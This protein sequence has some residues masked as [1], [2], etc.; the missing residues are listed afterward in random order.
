MVANPQWTDLVQDP[1]S[2][3]EGIHR[4]NESEVL[5]K[6]TGPPR[7]HDRPH[8]RKFSSS[9]YRNEPTAVVSSTLIHQ[10]L[11]GPGPGLVPAGPLLAACGPFNDSGPS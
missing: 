8:N 4:R 9:S 11:S 1:P 10:T 2:K 6:M 3:Y 5:A 7:T